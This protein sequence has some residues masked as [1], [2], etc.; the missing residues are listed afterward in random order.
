M[1][2]M[3]RESTTASVCVVEPVSAVVFSAL[4]LSQ[5]LTGLQL[6]GGL[7]I[8]MGAVL[9]VTSKRQPDEGG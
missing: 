5:K 3:K 8:L 7:V 6:L 1:E 9:V 4:L 2:G